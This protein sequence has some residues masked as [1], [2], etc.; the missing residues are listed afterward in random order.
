MSRT[1]V[2]IP[3][4]GGSKGIPRKNLR[5][6]NGMPMIYYSIKACLQSKVD[7]IVVSTDDD[8]IALL[9]SRFGADI[10][11]RPGELGEDVVTLDP[12]IENTVIKM[13]E[14]HNVR[15][16]KV[17]TVQPTSP[18]VQSADIND[19]LDLLEPGVDTII[20]AVD[21]RHLCWGV[22][23]DK[24]T[25][26]YHARVNRQSLPLNYK[27]TGAVVVCTREQLTSGNRVGNN[28]Q[29]YIMPTER[30]FDID[31]FTDLYLCE[32]ILTRRKICFVVVGYPKVGL[33]HAFRAVTLANELVNFDLTFLCEESSELAAQYISS[34]NY[35]VKRCKDGEIVAALE[36]ISPDII[37]NDILDTKYDYMK[38]IKSIQAKIVN[39]E[40]L[41]SSNKLA[42]ITINAL[43]PE[44][45]DASS[46]FSGHRYFCLRD[47]FIHL[48]NT[49]LNQEVENVLITFG[50]VDEGNL[51]KRALDIIYDVCNDRNIAVTV[52]L[53]PG[54]TSKKSLEKYRY[55]NEDVVTIVD[56]TQRISDY[57][58]NADLAITSGGR[59]VLELACVAVP[60]IV[61]C[62]NKRETTH[63][64]ASEKNG[65]INLGFRGT[66]GDSEIFSSFLMLIDNFK[67][68]KEMK[69]KCKR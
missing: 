56:S 40:D 2:V 16:D 6:I 37:I 55:P 10:Y 22:N 24:Y 63:T 46:V 68:R 67:I 65:I 62:Q 17:V 44:V 57:M 5:P 25:P 47:E 1:I 33:G 4:R 51:T 27:E 61:I 54:Y 38:S 31:T 53:G 9:A 14:K 39:F 21:D 29:L 15:Y 19:A 69:V 30:S 66:V 7:D 59:T 18:L 49:L 26:R 35:S 3:A 23:N 28:I 34:H 64:F 43:Y 20:S 36:R 50:G 42:D 60:T 58:I 11:M 8:E 45:S 41:S 32:A 48:D 52:V 12:V 13:E